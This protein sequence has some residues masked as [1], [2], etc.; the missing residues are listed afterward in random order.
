MEQF[1]KKLAASPAYARVAP[2]FIFLA[3]TACQGMF[4]EASRYWVYLLKTLVGAWLVWEMRPVVTEMRWAFSWEA[5]AVGIGVF[6][7]WVGLDPFVPKNNIFF[8][9]GGGPVLDMGPY[10]IGNLINLIGL[11]FI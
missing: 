2:F 1:R 6:V 11:N 4:G 10:Y 8:K 7:L 5:V 3:L 9:P